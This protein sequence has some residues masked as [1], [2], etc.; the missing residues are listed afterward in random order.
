VNSAAPASNKA[1][2]I[3]DLSQRISAI[4]TAKIDR[5]ITWICSAGVQVRW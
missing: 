5:S 3:L 2:Q 1:I 4:N